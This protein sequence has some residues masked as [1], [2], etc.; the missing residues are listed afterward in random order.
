MYCMWSLHIGIEHFEQLWF[1]YP[2]GV[3]ISTDKGATACVDVHLTLLL[4]FQYLFMREIFEYFQKIG[5]I[6]PSREISKI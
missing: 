4:F 2:F 1:S 5:F 3:G 6:P